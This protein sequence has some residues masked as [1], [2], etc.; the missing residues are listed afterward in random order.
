MEDTA[1]MELTVV[2]VTF[3]VVVVVVPSANA[4]V[5]RD[6]AI[7]RANNNAVMRLVMFMLFLLYKIIFFS[8]SCARSSPLPWA[9]T[10]S[11]VP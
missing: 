7:T 5:L 10:P 1:S 11:V 9:F 6:S 4:M 3:P 2:R 8:T